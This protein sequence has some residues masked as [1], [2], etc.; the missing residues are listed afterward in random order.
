MSRTVL[1]YVDEEQ[2]IA[3]ICELTE[4]GKAFQAN[5]QADAGYWSDWGEPV[6]LASLRETLRASA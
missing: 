6:V 1:V 2:E 5:N 3:Q 4:K